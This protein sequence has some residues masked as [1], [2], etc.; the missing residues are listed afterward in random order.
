MSLLSSS[1]LTVY[2]LILHPESKSP[3]LHPEFASRPPRSQHG[4]HKDGLWKLLALPVASGPGLPSLTA[5]A[6]SSW[7]SP[8]RDGPCRAATGSRVL[9]LTLIATRT[10][11][12]TP[13]AHDWEPLRLTLAH[14]MPV[15]LWQ[16]PR[17]RVAANLN[18]ARSLCAASASFKA[19][20]QRVAAL[21]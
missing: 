7:V 2:L 14:M 17:P 12:V 18:L 21:T 3:I 10:A 19:P 9:R 20:T 5:Q 16:G 1:L 4:L 11:G 8:S 6:C 13:E 15:M